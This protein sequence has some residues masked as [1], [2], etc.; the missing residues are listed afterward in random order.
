MVVIEHLH[1]EFGD[2]VESQRQPP[3][4]LADLADVEQ[5]DLVDRPALVS[6]GSLGHVVIL[7]HV[8]GRGDSSGTVGTDAVQQRH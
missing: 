8:R 5:P 7:A 6:D 1:R 3:V 2:D 4:E